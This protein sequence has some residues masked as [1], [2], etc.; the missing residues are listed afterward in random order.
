MGWL[1]KLAVDRV[2]AA[3]AEE[4]GELVLR[5]AFQRLKSQADAEDVA[6]LYP[7]GAGD[8]RGALGA[9][10]QGPGCDLPKSSAVDGG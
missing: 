8:D 7:G 4:Y 2:L 6:R 1:E 9:E 5:L 3:R 10:T